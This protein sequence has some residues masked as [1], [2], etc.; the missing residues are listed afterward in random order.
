M[1]EHLISNAIALFVIGF[2]FCGCGKNPENAITEK[3]AAS[4]PL[5]EP[6][7]VVDCEPGIPV[8]ESACPSLPRSAAGVQGRC[9]CLTNPVRE[10]KL[11]LCASS[12]KR[13]S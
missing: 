7:V 6:P 12:K 11:S 3:S 8:K 2:T 10:Y 13:F 9:S 1:K 5:P 4:Y